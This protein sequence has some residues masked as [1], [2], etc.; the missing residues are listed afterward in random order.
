MHLVEFDNLVQKATGVEPHNYI[1][2]PAP[3]KNLTDYYPAYGDIF[4]DFTKGFDYW[5]HTNWDC[6]YGRLNH[7]LPDSELKKA[8]I[9][10]DE[11]NEVNGTFSLY[12]NTKVINTLYRQVYSWEHAFT[13]HKLYG[14]DELQFSKYAVNNGYVTTPK[15]YPFLSYDRFPQHVPNPRLEYKDGR[16]Y[17]L[18][19]DTVTERTIGKEIMWFHFS[20]TKKWPL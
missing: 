2:G 18:F 7:F 10:A 15:G 1:D 19:T 13:D 3:H 8:E 11:K 4:K 20:Y 6:V 14:F 5:G 9:W 12:K 16:L 17:E